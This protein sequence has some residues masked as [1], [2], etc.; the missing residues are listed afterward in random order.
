[1]TLFA[2]ELIVARTRVPGELI[3]RLVPVGTKST[4]QNIELF[5]SQPLPPA[6][7]LLLNQILWLSGQLIMTSYRN[8]LSLMLRKEG[9]PVADY[10]LKMKGYVEKLER[11]GYKITICITWEKT[12][13]EI[14]A[15][16]IEYEK[17]LPKKAQTPQVM[18]I[19]GGKT[20]KANKKSLNAKGQNKVKD[21]GKDKKI[22][23]EPT[24]SPKTKAEKYKEDKE[25]P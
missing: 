22:P 12:V 19:K 18:M 14:H 15:M 9:K 25:K 2:K 4:V 3:K 20:E 5:A 1:M 23:N 16:L 6:L 8:C 11:L 7:I 17:G 24:S 10:V 21:K 13:G